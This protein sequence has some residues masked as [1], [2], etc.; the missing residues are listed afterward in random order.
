M[1]LTILLYQV[2]IFRLDNVDLYY[3]AIRSG[4][5]YLGEYFAMFTDG[6]VISIPM[7][8]DYEY[9][10]TDK[11]VPDEYLDWLRA[12]F[13]KER[14]TEEINHVKDV[15]LNRE[16]RPVEDEISESGCG[17]FSAFAGF[18]AL[19]CAAGAWVLVKK[20]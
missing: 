5:W 11:K 6:F 7:M 12:Y 2:Y 3:R 15:V 16:H 20:K 17:G 14:A 18:I 1:N 10:Y 19:A 8:Y 13:D 9:E 4:A